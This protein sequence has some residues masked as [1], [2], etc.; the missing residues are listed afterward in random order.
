LPASSLPIPRQ[1]PGWAIAASP[2]VH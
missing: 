1:F 2:S